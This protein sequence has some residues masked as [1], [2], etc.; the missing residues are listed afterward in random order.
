[1]N[2]PK[3]FVALTTTHGL[4]QVMF[5]PTLM[6]LFTHRTFDMVLWT[7]IDAYTP[8]ARNASAADFLK[9]D[10]THLMFIDVDILDPQITAHIDRM[11][12]HD[13]AIVGGF[14]PKKD[15][16]KLVWCCNALPERPTEDERGLI[17]LKHI[18]T[19]FMLIKREVFEKMIEQWGD[20]IGYLE[21]ETDRPLWDFFDMPRVGGR[22]L[23]EDWY[24][25]NK[26]RELGYKVYGD[27]LVQLMHIGTALFPLR[28]QAERTKINVLPDASKSAA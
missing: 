2:K 15:E 10:C 22:K 18:G 24:F 16:Q 17:S 28:H 27:T 7:Y 11:L 12:A 14:Y 13:E 9:G 21:D 23:S 26:S 1:M 3:V 19:G 6:N 5:V 25:C 8:L 4:M 20:Q